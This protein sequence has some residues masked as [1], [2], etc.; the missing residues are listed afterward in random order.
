[1]VGSN[2]INFSIAKGLP[3]FSIVFRLA[4]RRSTFKTGVAVV[5]FL[6]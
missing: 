5:Y 4:D 2:E 6:G 3:K 1:M